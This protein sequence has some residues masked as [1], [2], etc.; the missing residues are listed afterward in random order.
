MHPELQT[1]GKY[2]RSLYQHGGAVAG[3][4]LLT[5]AL[6]GIG[7]WSPTFEKDKPE[8]LSP[9]LIGAGFVITNYL[10]WRENW[11]K[12]GLERPSLPKDLKLIQSIVHQDSREP[13][14]V[15]F[16]LTLTSEGD[17][18]G[19]AV[20]IFC[21]APIYTKRFY[22]ERSVKRA[23]YKM[24]AG[25]HHR[26]DPKTGKEEIYNV[27]DIIEM[28]DKD[29][30]QYASLD[31]VEPI[32]GQAQDGVEYQLSSPESIREEDTN[33]VVV[34]DFGG[35]WLKTAPFKSIWGEI[36]STVPFMVTRVE[37][38]KIKDSRT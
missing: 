36:T 19:K 14:M 12:L 30:N 27:G 20:R 25:G 5:L 2:F 24:T 37:W 11:L 15:K 6:W 29:F 8:W 21:N 31:R 26:S 17:L 28:T 18:R 34:F 10:A 9:I 16:T 32:E 35:E 23:K 22:A 38:L 3:S 1:V 7:Q 4:F 33:T 13:E